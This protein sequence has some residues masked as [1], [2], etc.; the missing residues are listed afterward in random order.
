VAGTVKTLRV[1]WPAVAAG[2]LVSVAF[3]V[4]EPIALVSASACWLPF[5]LTT[6]ARSEVSATKAGLLDGVDDT[7]Q[8]KV[9]LVVPALTPTITFPTTVPVPAVTVA[10]QGAVFARGN[11]LAEAGE[12][13]PAANPPINAADADATTRNAENRDRID[14]EVPS[15]LFLL[16][17]CFHLYLL[18]VVTTHFMSFKR[19]CGGQQRL[20]LRI[21]SKR[22]KRFRRA[23]PLQRRHIVSRAR[24]SIVLGSTLVAQ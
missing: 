10:L 20:G 24:I 7:L 6:A 4:K 8:S 15:L 19:S 13:E 18:E 23:K 14:R 21:Q 1:H 9:I 5:V 22:K 17:I 3:A 2:Q 12:I 16:I 11:A